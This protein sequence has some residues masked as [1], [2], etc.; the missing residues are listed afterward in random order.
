MIKIELKGMKDD[1]LTNH[2]FE[3]IILNCL[4]VVLLE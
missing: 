1:V 3:L 2:D 4:E